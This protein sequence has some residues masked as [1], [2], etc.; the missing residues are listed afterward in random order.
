MGLMMRHPDDIRSLAEQ[1]TAEIRRDVVRYRLA[2][3]AQSVQRAH[4][5][6]FLWYR[7]RNILFRLSPSLGHKFMPLE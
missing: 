2:E 5:R 7:I 1:R 3:Q 4:R 6:F